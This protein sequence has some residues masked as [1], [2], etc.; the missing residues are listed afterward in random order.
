MK[1]VSENVD[2]DVRIGDGVVSIRRKGSTEIILAN[3]VATTPA[4]VGVPTR[5]WLDR[6]VH[7]AHETNIGQYPVKGAFVTEL[8]LND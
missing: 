4:V 2:A 3:V 5:L 6:L 8:S 1:S 7:A